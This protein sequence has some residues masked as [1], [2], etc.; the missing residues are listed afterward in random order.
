MCP[1]LRRHVSPASARPAG[2]SRRA[3]WRSRRGSRQRR[4]VATRGSPYVLFGGTHP[5]GPGWKVHPEAPGAASCSTKTGAPQ[6]A[7]H[8]AASSRARAT[9]RAAARPP[10]GGYRT[11]AH[12][13][14]TASITRTEPP[15][16]ARAAPA[17]ARPPGPASGAPKSGS[18]KIESAGLEP[19]RPPRAPSTVSMLAEYPARARSRRPRRA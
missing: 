17:A 18:R 9:C 13:A 8:S 10:A 3:R 4:L 1:E 6:P 16:S 15:R 19:Q 2:T 12:P 5:R 7:S 14:N 11:L